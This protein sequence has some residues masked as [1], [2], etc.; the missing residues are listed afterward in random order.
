VF[1]S[2]IARDRVRFPEHEP[3]VFDGRHKAVRIELAVFRRVHDTVLHA[4]ID[5]LAAQTE[6]LDA[7]ERLLHV[8]RIRPAPQLQ[9]RSSG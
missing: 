7:P 1:R 9:H 3:V 2:E 5:A 4:G 8:H 6:L